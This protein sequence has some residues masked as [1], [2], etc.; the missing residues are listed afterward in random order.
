MTLLIGF[1]QLDPTY[2]APEPIKKK[3]TKLKKKIEM[4]GVIIVPKTNR[5]TSDT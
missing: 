5:K 2:H 4:R 3:K 1:T